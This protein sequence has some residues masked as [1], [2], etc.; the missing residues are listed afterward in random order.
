MFITVILTATEFK[1][2]FK[3]RAHKDAQPEIKWVA[4]QMLEAYKNSK[5]QELGFGEWHVPMLQPGDTKTPTAELLKISTGRCARISYLTH[6]GRRDTKED[7][8][9]HD[10]LVKSG[11]WSPFEHQAVA[12]ISG[13]DCGN[14]TGFRPYRKFFADESGTN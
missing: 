8:A 7:V 1:N 13:F 11:H 5:P 10:R 2:W 3:L 6:D 14:F 12:V 4:E 9:L